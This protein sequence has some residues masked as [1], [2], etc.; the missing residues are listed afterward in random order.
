MGSKSFLQPKSLVDKLEENHRV[1][2]KDSEH[3]SG[4]GIMGL[5]FTSGH[6][7]GLR[8]FPASS[9]GPG[10]TSVW[11][12]NP[13]G[14]WTFFQDKT[15]ELACSRYFGKA[16]SKTLIC[17]IVIKWTDSNSFTVTIDDDINLYWRVSL[18]HTP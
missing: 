3:F 12:R 9:V 6:I 2:R 7:L 14:R 4:Y 10:Y 18:I 11:Y 8:R 17:D 15:P 13:Q 16:I 5:T 1:F